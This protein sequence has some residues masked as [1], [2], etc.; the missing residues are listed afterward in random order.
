LGDQLLS[1]LTL[2]DDLLGGLSGSFHG[3]VTG[4]VW[5]D[6]D[7]HSPRTDFQGPREQDLA[8]DAVDMHMQDEV[9]NGR[10]GR[11]ALEAQSPGLGR[12][13]GGAGEQNAQIPH[14]L[15]L[16]EDPEHRH[17]EHRYQPRM[18]TLRRMRA[19]GLALRKLIRS[20]SVAAEAVL[21]TERKRFCRPQPMVA[22]CARTP[23]TH[24]ESA[25]GRAPR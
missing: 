5:P 7:S 6:A 3:G 12:R 16:A 20:R 19:S 22:A 10:I 1:G 18:R 4:P 13:Q 8:A 25:L 2:A 15:A 9:T 21:S 23:V 17:Q 11:R 14:A 24:F